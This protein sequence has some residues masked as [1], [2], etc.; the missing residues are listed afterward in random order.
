MEKLKKIFKINCEDY[1][2]YNPKNSGF[3]NDC[4]TERKFTLLTGFH[5]GS[6]DIPQDNDEYTTASEWIEKYTYDQ[7]GRFVGIKKYYHATNGNVDTSEH[8][9]TELDQEIFK[10]K[11]PNS[12]ILNEDGSI[13]YDYRKYPNVDYQQH[14]KMY[15][16]IIVN[17]EFFQLAPENEQINIDINDILFLGKKIDYQFEDYTEI[18]AITKNLQE[19]VIAK[20]WE[21][22]YYSDNPDF[23][24]NILYI[25]PEI[26]EHIINNKPQT[27]KFVWDKKLKLFLDYDG[28]EIEAYVYENNKFEWIATFKFDYYDPTQI[29]EDDEE[30]LL[31][32][33]EDVRGL[34]YEKEI[35]EAYKFAETVEYFKTDQIPEWSDTEIGILWHLKFQ[36]LMD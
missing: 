22:D 11:F 28:Y 6:E 13:F 7:F 15:P 5:L 30:F 3:F 18:L 1:Y 34:K 26:Y 21:I 33:E 27:N 14:Y 29:E 9:I 10:K 31:Y 17:D 8:Y 32:L 36:F 25:Q 12:A 2:S 19:I 35:L 4:K 24:P 20:L 23:K 16:G